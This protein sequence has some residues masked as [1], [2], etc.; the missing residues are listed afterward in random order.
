MLFRSNEEQ[1]SVQA[2]LYAD[3]LERKYGVRPV[4]YYTNG[5]SI[6][7]VDGIYPARIV[8]GFHKKD[9]L[10][11]IIQKRNYSIID[12]DVRSDI[13]D[14][15]YQKDAIDEV[16]KHL[17]SKHTRSLIVLA[18]GTGK[19]RVSCAISD[20]LIRNNYAK[21]ILFL[22][23]RVNLV[24]QAKEET[25]DKFLDTVPTALICEGVREGNEAQARDRKSVV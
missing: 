24:K 9:E 12:K 2:K 14:R 20:I 21:R 5:Y 1:G 16:L 7:I 6:K 25:F 18:T 15:Y 22:A 13:C 17:E 3:C 11:H 10:E 19:T 8:F 23:D 4:I